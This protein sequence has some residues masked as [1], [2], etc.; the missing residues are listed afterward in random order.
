[1]DNVQKITTIR[2]YS[3]LD[4]CGLKKICLG[5]RE[6]WTWGQSHGIGKVWTN[7]EYIIEECN[8]VGRHNSRRW[9]WNLIKKKSRIHDKTEIFSLC[10]TKGSGDTT[11]D[12]L[13]E[14]VIEDHCGVVKIVCEYVWNSVDDDEISKRSY[15]K[16]IEKAKKKKNCE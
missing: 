14:L 9:W 1:M 15:L 12:D 7:V 11:H 16:K 2:I 6:Q 10:V 13:S 4:R 3:K 8:E 5:A